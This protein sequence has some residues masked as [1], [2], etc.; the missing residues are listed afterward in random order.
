ML[1]SLYYVIHFALFL[2]NLGQFALFIILIV[3][4][5]LERHTFSLGLFCIFCHHY[6]QFA[7]C[8]VSIL[9]QKCQNLPLVKDFSPVNFVLSCEYFVTHRPFL[10]FAHLLDSFRSIFILH[11]TRCRIHLQKA[12]Y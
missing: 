10:I 4:E 7:F 9:S 12:N 2:L 1:I 6:L 8:F 3:I 5:A 11:K